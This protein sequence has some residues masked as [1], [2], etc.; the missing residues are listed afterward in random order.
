[1]PSPITPSTANSIGGTCDHHLATNKSMRGDI[2]GRNPLGTAVDTRCRTGLDMIGKHSTAVMPST[3][4]GSIEC[5][6]RR[7]PGQKTR[8]SSSFW[9]MYLT[10]TGCCE[11][12]AAANF[13]RQSGQLL[14]VAMHLRQNIF[15][16]QERAMG[17][18]S[19]SKQI[20]HIRSS[21]T[22]FSST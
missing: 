8:I 5:R 16:Q 6:W 14:A 18:N 13:A 7:T 11:T 22:G 12:P 1:M 9:V 19:G 21:S 15:P 3:N 2:S 17:S 4:Y 20:G 10:I